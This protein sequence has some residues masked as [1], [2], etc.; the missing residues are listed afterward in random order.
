MIF[1]YIRALQDQ[2][3]SPVMTLPRLTILTDKGKR[4]APQSMLDNLLIFPD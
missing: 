1:L 3:K 4:K 2:E